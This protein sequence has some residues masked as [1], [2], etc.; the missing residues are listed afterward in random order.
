MKT[1]NGK[2]S[3][4]P[5]N[6][7][8]QKPK[9]LPLGPIL[10][11]IAVMT[12]VF[13]LL[14]LFLPTN[15]VPPLGAII[16]GL[17]F[18]IILVRGNWWGPLTAIVTWVTVAIVIFILYFLI[19]RPATVIGTVV[20]VTTGSPISG[21]AL[22]LT[23]SGGVEHKASTDQNGA[24][25]VK[26]VPEGKF[27]VLANNELLFSGRLP[28]GFERILKS[29]VDLGKPAYKS[30]PSCP[31]PTPCPSCPIPTPCPSCPTP[32][33][34]PSCPTSAPFSIFTDKGWKTYKREESNPLID[35]ASISGRVDNAIEVT[36]DIQR[37]S[38]V[39]I[40]KDITPGLLSGTS[41]I[42]FIYKG[43]GK[44]NTLEFKLIDEQGTVFS[45]L[46]NS[47]TVTNDK[48][49][50]LGVLYDQ[51]ECWKTTGI[52]PDNQVL[53]LEPAK[54]VKIDFAFSNKVDTEDEPGSGKVIID[55][56]YVVQP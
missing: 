47:A 51:F 8:A 1:R 44:P 36:F 31:I 7:Q 32:A 40:S 4:K 10:T 34:C 19:S 56:I 53:N 9:A 54:I 41:G 37:D 2:P 25:E 50:L 17:I 23:D 30:C 11:I 12:S 14:Q 16:I 21:L 49:I 5:T 20:D 35:I 22:V 33:P 3:R 15:I 6:E 29:T 52:C 46:W 13:G 38:W 39:G 28:S 42:F 27:K 24:F 43:E 55:D 45:V 26:N 48:W 18:T